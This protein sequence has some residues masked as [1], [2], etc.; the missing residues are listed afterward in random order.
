MTVPTQAPAADLPQV[1]FRRRRRP[2]ALLLLAGLVLGLVL[3]AAYGVLTTGSK[4]ATAYLVVAPLTTGDVQGDAGGATTYAKAYAEVAGQPDVLDSTLARFA[5]GGLSVDEVAEEITI[6]ASQDAPLVQ[7]DVAADDAD[8]AVQIA[9]AA[10]DAVVTYLTTSAASSGYGVQVLTPAAQAR[11]ASGLSTPLT[12]VL[13]GV[14][15]LV[16]A[17]AVLVLR[18]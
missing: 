16:A 8:T 13:G 5:V 10:S 3:G 17:G 2:V 14:L 18:R 1:R 4:H 12:A 6:S 7:V 11:S 9:S 15:G